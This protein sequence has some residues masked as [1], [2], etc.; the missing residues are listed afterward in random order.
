MLYGEISQDGGALSQPSDV[1]DHDG[2]GEGYVAVAEL[3]CDRSEDYFI[4]L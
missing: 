1:S 4:L 3:I 2:T